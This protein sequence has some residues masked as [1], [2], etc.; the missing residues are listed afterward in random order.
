MESGIQI[1]K[2]ALRK[3]AEQARDNNLDPEEA[4]DINSRLHTLQ[5]EVTELDE[6]SRVFWLDCQ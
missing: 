3:L 2:T 5:K 6:Q 1:Y 4:Q